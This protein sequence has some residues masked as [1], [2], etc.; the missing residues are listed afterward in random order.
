[1]L[2][3]T[4]YPCFQSFLD[5]NEC[6]SVL[7]VCGDW[8]TCTDTQGSFQC[9]CDDGFFSGNGQHDDCAGSIGQP[10]SFKTEIQL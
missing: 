10:K 5:I 4:G 8:S 9:Q 2:L 7:A 3:R 6:D 1:M